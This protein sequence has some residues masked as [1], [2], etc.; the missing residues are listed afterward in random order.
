MFIYESC[1]RKSISQGFEK[2]GG[3]EWRRR[4]KRERETRGE[5]GKDGLGEEE[6]QGAVP[7]TSYTFS[8]TIIYIPEP[9]SLCDATSATEKVFDILTRSARALESG[10]AGGVECQLGASGLCIETICSVIIRQEIC[11]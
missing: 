7:V 6:S 9:A 8:S 1:S 2:L 11:K 5:G 4:A 3:S 10:S